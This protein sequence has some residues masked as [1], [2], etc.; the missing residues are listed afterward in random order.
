MKRLVYSQLEAWNSGKSRKPLIINGARQVGKTYILKEFANQAFENAHYFNFEKVPKLSDA[1]K[2]SLNPKEILRLLSLISGNQFNVEKDLIIFDEI[3]ACPRAL[4]SFKYFNEDMPNLPVCSAG[5]L[6]GVHLG[7]VSF[8]VGKV[9]QINMYPMN[10][11]EFLLAFGEQGLAEA[12]KHLGELSFPE[13]LH[14]K[15]LDLLK[16]YLIT[17]GLP[18]VVSLYIDEKTNQ[19]KAFERV[20]ERQS[21]LYTNYMADMV[22]HSGKVNT[23]HIERIFHSIPSQLGR[24][25][26]ETSAKFRFKDVVANGRYDRLAGPIGWLEAAGLA[27]KIP[28]IS[29]ANSPLSAQTKDSSFKL[30]MF[31]VGVFGAIAD[32]SPNRIMLSDY[33]TFKGYFIENFVLQSLISNGIKPLY[34]WQ[35]GKSEVE[36]LYETRGEIIPIEVKSGKNIRAKSLG[37]FNQKYSPNKRVKFSSLPFKTSSDGSLYSLPLYSSCFAKDSGVFE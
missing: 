15:A 18:E 23:M 2:D 10:F 19:A 9:S 26:D 1:F 34:C 8:P 7:E 32:L 17:G 37:V 3:Q 24:D 30:Q 16:Q 12:M 4:T 31:D 33:G 11:E 14:C 25:G 6:L 35:E 28:M 21:E 5:S 13:A 27:Y 20:R 36:F 22:K 29:N